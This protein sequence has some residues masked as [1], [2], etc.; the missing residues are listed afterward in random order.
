MTRSPNELLWTAKKIDVFL[1]RSSLSAGGMKCFVF[2]MKS[3]VCHFSSVEISFQANFHL[4]SPMRTLSSSQA[5]SFAN[6]E[7]VQ[8]SVF[9]GN[10][11]WFAHSRNHQEPLRQKKAQLVSSCW[12]GFFSICDNFW[13]A[14]GTPDSEI[15][16][17]LCKC[18]TQKLSGAPICGYVSL[19]I[20]RWG[21]PW[22]WVWVVVGH[23]EVYSR[24]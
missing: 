23:R 10:N 15:V 8:K 18:G 4:I 7:R 21:V 20:V 2:E 9:I 17:K 12:W 6:L 3:L 5:I 13:A 1:V 19:W 14:S 22:A 11:I 24:C 16:S